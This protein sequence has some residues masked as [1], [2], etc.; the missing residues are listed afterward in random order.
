M[1]LNLNLDL[2]CIPA[3]GERQ[4]RFGRVLNTFVH[5]AWMPEFGKERARM[6]SEKMEKLDK[7]VAASGNVSRA[8]KDMGISRSLYYKWKTAVK[9]GPAG[10]DG[11]VMEGAGERQPARK[12]PQAVPDHVDGRIRALAAEY[13]DWGCDRISYFLSLKGDKVSATTVQKILRR[14]GL[15]SKALRE[16]RLF[17]GAG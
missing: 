16:R 7:A 4:G 3:A 13:P 11:P 8:C 14:N 1:R 12:H 9:N 5:G 6:E 2:Q 15:G 10:Q 17:P